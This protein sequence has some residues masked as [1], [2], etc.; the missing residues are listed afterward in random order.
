ML[1][2][3]RYHNEVIAAIFSVRRR[4][5][6]THPLSRSLSE[7]LLRFLVSKGPVKDLYPKVSAS[8]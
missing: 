6:F 4:A 2:P 7:F 3:P 5:S 8:L 1:Y